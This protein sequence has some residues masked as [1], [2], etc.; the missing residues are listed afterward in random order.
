LWLALTSGDVG[1]AVKRIREQAVSGTQFHVR[2][3]V[4][5]HLQWLPWE[6]LYDRSVGALAGVDA[7]CIIHDPPREIRFPPVSS[8]GSTELSMLLIVPERSGLNVGLELNNIRREAAKRGIHVASLTDAVTTDAVH[9]ELTRRRWDIVHYVGHGQV[10]EAD[11]RTE[12]VLNH[13]TGGEQWLDAEVFARDSGP[14]NR[15]AVMN[16]CFGVGSAD[17]RDSLNGLGPLLLRRGV[18]AVVAMRYAIADNMAIRFSNELYRTLFDG[19]EPGRIDLAV[20]TARAAL[21]RNQS[22]DAIRS[23]ITP[24]LHLANGYER[25]F[26]FVSGAAAPTAIAARSTTEVTPPPAVSLPAELLAA[27]CDRRCV[28]VIGQGILRLGACRSK[29]PPG[30]FE[31]ATELARKRGRAYPSAEDIENCRRTGEWM[32]S[33]LLQWVC[34]L[35]LQDGKFPELLESLIETYRQFQPT[36]MIEQ[37]ARWDVPGMFYT[38]FDGLLEDSAGSGGGRFTRIIRQ[39]NELAAADPTTLG[40]QRLL[41]LLRG[42]LTDP[43]SLVLT[44]SDHS[45]LL[46][47]IVNMEAGIASIAK[48]VRRSVLFLGVSPRDPLIRQLAHKLIEGGKRRRQGPTYFLA[49]DHTEIDDACGEEFDVKWLDGDLESLLHSILEAAP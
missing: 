17:R 7:Y 6:S 43:A 15:L 25:L 34:Q 8:R 11:G 46:A 2:L 24:V 14:R 19:P 33:Q 29:S 39:L 32:S 23:F 13:P 38:F 37:L 31:L 22:K 27:I 26:D 28:P 10:N 30:P 5:G 44:E 35:Y 41:I 49:S 42:S 48:Q 21:L 40:R 45:R 20:E 16:C 4:P 12:I 36:P 18:P 47:S 9:S 1:P 3:E